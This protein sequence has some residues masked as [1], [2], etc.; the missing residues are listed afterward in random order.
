MNF[1]RTKPAGEIA[2]VRVEKPLRAVEL[3]AAMAQ[4]ADN[5][6]P[7]DGTRIVLVRPLQDAARNHGQVLLMKDTTSDDNREMAVKRMP[8]RWVCTDPQK[9]DAKYPTASEKPWQDLGFV[10]HLRTVDFPY[11]CEFLGMYRSDEDT[12]VATSFCDQGDLFGWCDNDRVPDPGPAREDHMRPILAQIFAG[13]RW[14]HD[15]G[16]AHRDLSLE[17]ILLVGGI[18]NDAHVKIIDFGMATLQRKTRN[19]VRGKNSYQAPET[20]AGGDVDTFLADCFA[21][22][23]VMFAMGAQ[24]YPWTCTR[25]GKCQLFEYV[26]AFGMRKFL[27]KRRLRKGNGEFLSEVFTP[28]FIDTVDGLLLFDPRQ[29]T[30]IGEETFQED[31]RRKKRRSSWETKYFQGVDAGVLS[32]PRSP[33]A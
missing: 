15:L 14:L 6:Q 29:R 33:G 13:V 20:F 8:T 23:V 16:I 31:L 32:S 26:N 9:F 28:D 30:C 18:G 11:V 24:D 25:R 2:T 3:D 17:N 1:F 7:W 12:Y 27:D 21:L 5:V 10:Q 19:E 4:I 22:G